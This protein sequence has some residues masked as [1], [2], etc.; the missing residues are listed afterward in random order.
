MTYQLGGLLVGTGDTDLGESVA[1][2]VNDPGPL[3]GDGA[4]PAMLNNGLLTLLSLQI[5]LV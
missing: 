4:A 2:P 1:D 5:T 3:D